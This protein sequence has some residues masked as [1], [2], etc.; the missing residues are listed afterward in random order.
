MEEIGKKIT[1]NIGKILGKNISDGEIRLKIRESYEE[2]L[3]F[4][5]ELVNI[6]DAS[7]EKIMKRGMFKEINEYGFAVLT[8]GKGE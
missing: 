1:I 8:N 5:G 4:Q 2:K 3:M 6:Y 7:L